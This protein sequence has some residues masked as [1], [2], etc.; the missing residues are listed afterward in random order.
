[1]ARRGANALELSMVYRLFIALELPDEVEQAL[2]SAQRQLQG[3]RPP[4]KWVAPG[5]MHLTLRFLGDTDAGL[6]EPLGAAMSAALGN[7]PAPLLHLGA[8]GAFP[9]L[10]RPSVVWVGLGG[11]LEGLRRL[12][13]ALEEP[14]AALG[15]PPEERRFHPHL[16]LGRVR[17]DAGPQEQRRLGELVRSLPV[18]AASPW[19][20]GRVT[21]FRS[22]LRPSGSVYTALAGTSLVS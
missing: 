11:D 19:R 1:M 10:S 18:P 6:V 13:A 14:L 4:V 20:A 8:A 12:H 9:G 3:E 22:E 15:F 16:T 5:A 21:L 7:L 2:E 17:R